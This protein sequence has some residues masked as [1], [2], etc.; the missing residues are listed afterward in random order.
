MLIDW[1]LFLGG[2][3]LFLVHPIHFIY[4]IFDPNHGFFYIKWD[5]TI[6]Q[7]P[8]YFSLAYRAPNSTTTPYSISNSGIASWESFPNDRPGI[9]YCSYSGA[10]HI[11]PTP[12][13]A[14]S[15]ETETPGTLL[16]KPTTL[17]ASTCFWES[18]WESGRS[19]IWSRRLHWHCIQSFSCP[20]D[21]HRSVNNTHL[22]YFDLKENSTFT[23]CRWHRT[24][25]PRYEMSVSL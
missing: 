22:H 19:S 8:A 18:L 23:V 24:V 3:P 2:S 7:P 16:A 9:S 14:F 25:F 1:L 10:S 13:L 6:T 20:R 15:L 4:L 12:D 5:S 17:W 11:V 21:L